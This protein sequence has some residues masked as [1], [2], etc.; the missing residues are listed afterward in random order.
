LLRRWL[1]ALAIISF[2]ALQAISAVHLHATVEG[3]R[4]CSA[5]SAVLHHPAGD[6]ATPAPALLLATRMLGT[7]RVILADVLSQQSFSRPSSR[8]PPRA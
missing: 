4:D 3:E 6:A 1:A 2:L 7:T 5:C 8:A